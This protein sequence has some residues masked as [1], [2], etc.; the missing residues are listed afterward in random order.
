MVETSRFGDSN[1][2]LRVARSAVLWLVVLPAVLFSCGCTNLTVRKYRNEKILDSYTYALG[3]K[4]VKVDGL[5]VCYQEMGSGEDVLVLPGLGTSIDFWQDNLPAIAKYYHVVAMDVP[6]FGKSD[7]P[8]VSYTLP[9]LVEKIVHFMDVKG[10]KRPIIIGGSL[11]G[12]EA[13]LLALEHPDRV[14]KLILMGS[15]GAWKPPGPILRLGL[16]TLWWDMAVADYMRGRWP[17]IYPKLFETSPRF[18]MGIFRYQMAL[19]ADGSKYWPTGRAAS[20]ALRNIFFASC[21]GR[22]GEIKC[23]VLLVWGKDDKIHPSSGQGMYFR[24]HLPNSTLVIVPH[25]AH[26][27]MADQP[28][29][30]NHLVLEF[31]RGKRVEI[32]DKWVSGGAS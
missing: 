15:V 4:Y 1:L 3:E 11:G 5:N 9:W 7:K 32:K 29:I 20:R 21:R 22:L 27:V 30:F 28:V 19:R 25:S 13:L 17:E 12:H 14:S 31:L 8:N 6:G 23:P 16:K 18:T 2:R 26:E 10:L 24:K